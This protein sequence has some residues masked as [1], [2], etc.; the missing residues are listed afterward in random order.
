[1]DILYAIIGTL[2]ALIIYHVAGKFIEHAIEDDF[3][4]KFLSEMVFAA[5]ALIM[6]FLLKQTALFKNDRKK[7]K[8]GWKSAGLL[9]LTMVVF[10]VLSIPNLLLSE[11]TA[12]HWLLFLG[13]VILVGFAEEVLFRG[14]I[15]GALHRYFGE[16]S[17]K[18]VLLAVICTGVLFG[19]A[20][21]INLV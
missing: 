16:N 3:V 18:E 10:G 8:S 20:H 13:M 19:L 12:L 11:E 1:M 14:L 5:G 15:Q 9:I 2:A 6:V 21:L 4:N 17:A 7:I